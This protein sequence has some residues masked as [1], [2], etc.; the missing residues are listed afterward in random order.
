MPRPSG[1][2]TVPH[3]RPRKILKSPKVMTH[4][5]ISG[6]DRPWVSEIPTQPTTN[7]GRN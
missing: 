1:L 2:R 5:Q 6:G 3:D 7:L 4:G